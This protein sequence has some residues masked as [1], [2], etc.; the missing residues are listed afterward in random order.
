K[1]STL[2][3]VTEEQLR[4]N[5][6]RIICNVATETVTQKVEFKKKKNEKIKVKKVDDLHSK[7]TNIFGKMI[8]NKKAVEN[9][10]N[11]NAVVIEDTDVNPSSDQGG[12][13]NA[14]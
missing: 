8:K 14:K 5:L 10:V 9:E 7:K 3:V 4:K 1:N 6:E 2:E 12:D 11:T 13:D